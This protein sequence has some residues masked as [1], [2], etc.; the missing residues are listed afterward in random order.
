MATKLAS[1][2]LN[3]Y[4]ALVNAFAANVVLILRSRKM[5]GLEHMMRF[6]LEKAL[7]NVGGSLL[8]HYVT[9]MWNGVNPLD[10]EYLSQA[11]AAG[12]SSFWK[13]HMSASYLAQEQLMISLVSHLIATKSA[14]YAL[15]Y[16]NQNLG[17]TGLETIN[18]NLGLY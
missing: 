4:E 3:I 7:I 2:G 10:I 14:D 8:S 18:P 12:I 5:P 9:P 11:L 15:P 16:V 17:N 13:P 1:Y 6:G